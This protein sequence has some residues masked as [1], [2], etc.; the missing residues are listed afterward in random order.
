MNPL[1]GCLS[2]ILQIVIILA[3]FWLVSQPLTYMVRVNNDETLKNLVEGYK[4]EIDINT[5]I[6]NVVIDGKDDMKEKRKEVFR[7]EFD[8]V[9]TNGMTA[10][11]YI[12]NEVFELIG[13]KPQYT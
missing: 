13:R 9:K 2:G 5:F 6:Q 12:C 8:Y 3:V 1:S 10:S 7:E 11:D 4:T